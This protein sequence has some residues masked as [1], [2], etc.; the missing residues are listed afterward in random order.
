MFIFLSISLVVSSTQ[1]ESGLVLGVFWYLKSLGTAGKHHAE[2]TVL[3]TQICRH[4]SP[5]LIVASVPV[6][7]ETD[8]T[9][10]NGRLII[11]WKKKKKAG[12]T[13]NDYFESTFLH[14]DIIPFL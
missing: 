9:A 2:P 7:I 4:H 8:H 11:I 13:A 12:N 14:F 3:T 1:N 5:F 6:A 10:K